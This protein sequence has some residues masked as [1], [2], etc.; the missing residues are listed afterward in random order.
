VRFHALDA[1]TEDFH[2]LVIAAAKV[3]YS[4]TIL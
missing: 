1:F 3:T 4:H 2:R